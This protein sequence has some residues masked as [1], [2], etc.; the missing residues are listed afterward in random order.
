MPPP[1]PGLSFIVDQFRGW[2]SV[3]QVN[4]KVC[5]CLDGARSVIVREEGEG[6]RGWLFRAQWVCQMG[7][8]QQFTRASDN[9]PVKYNPAR[10]LSLSLLV[11]VVVVRR[12][13]KY[14]KK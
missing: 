5:V 4:S 11:D 10:R 6:G 14:P 2:L 9:T 7:L 1:P 13:R 12:D 3:A 8:L